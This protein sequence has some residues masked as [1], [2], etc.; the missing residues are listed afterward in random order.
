MTEVVSRWRR[1]ASIALLLLAS[2]TTK[3][4]VPPKHEELANLRVS[5]STEQDVTRL[6]GHPAGRGQVHTGSL[7]TARDVWSYE[8]TEMSGRTADLDFL[9]VFMLDGRYDGHLWFSSKSSFEYTQ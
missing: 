1:G 9:L 6:L 2:C 8:Y 3:L 5:V 4:G 7:G